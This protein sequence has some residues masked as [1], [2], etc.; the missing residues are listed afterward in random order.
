MYH[1]LERIAIVEIC[2]RLAL[3]LVLLSNW[4]AAAEVLSAWKPAPFG[5]IL[6]AGI[7][8]T[9]LVAAHIVTERRVYN[10]NK[11]ASAPHKS[12]AVPASA[13][14]FFAALSGVANTH[15]L[16]AREAGLVA[17]LLFGAS[18]PLAA[19]FV[20]Y[21]F[22]DEAANARK[23]AEFKEDR[24]LKADERR[25]RRIER[26][27]MRALPA[28]DAAYSANGAS[29]NAGAA[30]HNASTT[31]AYVCECGE[32]FKS[33]QAYAAHKRWHCGVS[34]EAGNGKGEDG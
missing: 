26:E 19:V 10:T 3:V 5:H 11:L 32:T 28:H 25:I 12:L 8:V 30:A 18:A 2:S 14:V 7:E 16:I 9:L 27:H 34:A 17:A 29:N 15:Y 24:A 4:W 6:A 21:L 20:A 1:K 31:G 23:V 13:L 22:G 33:S